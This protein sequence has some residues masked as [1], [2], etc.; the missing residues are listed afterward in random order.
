M[1]TSSPSGLTD[2]NWVFKQKEQMTA[3]HIPSIEI[4][5]ILNIG[6][7]TQMGTH[8]VSIIFRVLQKSACFEIDDIIARK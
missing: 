1:D 5:L 6:T 3:E 7:N 8:V 4:A 2:V